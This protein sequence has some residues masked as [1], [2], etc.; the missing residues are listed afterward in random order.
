M[1]AYNHQDIIAIFARGS[2]KR[3]CPEPVRQLPPGVSPLEILDAIQ[4]SLTRSISTANL[5]RILQL[6]QN[7]DSSQTVTDDFDS[8][9]VLADN[10]K[11]PQVGGKL[12]E[13]SIG[14]QAT[15]V[16]SIPNKPEGNDV[17]S[18]PSNKHPNSA[19]PRLSLPPGDLSQLNDAFLSETLAQQMRCEGDII[20]NDST[21]GST[22]FT[23]E[24]V[25]LDSPETV[26]NIEGSQ[27]LP[28][29]AS[30]SRKDL[31]GIPT[32]NP[33]VIQNSS[34][35][36]EHLYQDRV[37]FK[38]PNSARIVFSTCADQPV[39]SQALS[40]FNG[41]LE[42]STKS[43]MR[44]SQEQVLRDQMEL[45]R[46]NSTKM[47]RDARVERAIASA[48]DAKRVI[49]SRATADCGRRGEHGRNIASGSIPTQAT[50]AEIGN[51]GGRS[52]VIDN[53]PEY[54]SNVSVSQP[55]NAALLERTPQ[56]E[57]GGNPSHH[58]DL[59]IYNSK[60]A[61]NNK[62]ERSGLDRQNDAKRKLRIAAQQV[63]KQ[64]AERERNR[65]SRRQKL[66]ANPPNYCHVQSLGQDPSQNVSYG[67]ECSKSI[68]AIELSEKDVEKNATTDVL[69]VPVTVG[70][71]PYTSLHITAASA[72]AI[73]SNT[74][75]PN[76]RSHA[77]SSSN[78]GSSNATVTKSKEQTKAIETQILER[79]CKSQF[80]KHVNSGVLNET[81]SALVPDY[82][83]ASSN[84]PQTQHI[85]NNI[86]SMLDSEAAEKNLG[87][88][89]NVELTTSQTEG[90]NGGNETDLISNPPP[91]IATGH[92][93]ID[94]V[95]SSRDGEY[96]VDSTTLPIIIGNHCNDH[97]GSE[98]RGDSNSIVRDSLSDTTIHGDVA[99]HRQLIQSNEVTDVGKTTG[100]E[101]QQRCKIIG[102]WAIVEADNSKN[103]ASQASM[104]DSENL[105][106]ERMRDL[107]CKKLR[108]QNISS[109]NTIQ[110]YASNK[111]QKL[112]IHAL[113]SSGSKT[114]TVH[115]DNSK[116]MHQSIE[117]E[118]MEPCISNKGPRQK[119]MQ[120]TVQQGQ[121]RSNQSKS[122]PIA[123]QSMSSRL[124]KR[125]GKPQAHGFAS[126]NGTPITKS[127]K[128]KGQGISSGA[129][130]S[131]RSVPLSRRNMH[132]SDDARILAIKN[133][134]SAY[135]AQK[136]RDIDVLEE[137]H[138]NVEVLS[139]GHVGPPLSH[140][141]ESSS[142]SDEDEDEEQ[143]KQR[144]LL[145]HSS[146]AT[147]QKVP[148][149]PVPKAPDSQRPTYARKGIGGKTILPQA[150]ANDDSKPEDTIPKA[151]PAAREVSTPSDSDT[152]KHEML[153][154]YTV[155]RT[156]RTTRTTRPSSDSDSDT[157][158]DEPLGTFLT[159]AE[160]N[161][162]ATTRLQRLLA[163]GFLE[164]AITIATDASG[165]QT[166]HYLTPSTSTH[167]R[168]TRAVARKVRL[169]PSAAR[170]PRL[171]YG[172]YHR[173]IQRFRTST[174]PDTYTY[175]HL[176]T[177]SL[178]DLANR[179]AGRAWLA[180]QLRELAPTAY[181]QQVTAV[182]LQ[183]EMREALNRL[184][185]EG[186]AFRRNAR[187]WKGGG[188]AK[189]EEE[190]EV[191][192]DE[193]EVWGPRN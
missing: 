37:L 173:V 119:K 155:T 132:L 139:N 88:L 78:I 114:G 156:T 175:L 25:M 112:E 171:V 167:I 62:T 19:E 47:Q 33:K 128:I 58:N 16:V 85:N 192:V 63:R 147:T 86:N 153:W 87:F 54:P 79:D 190:V 30:T 59:Q 53:V 95:A 162:V 160:A 186:V 123:L 121:Q 12:P 24:Y 113:G 180:Y 34:Q 61:E 2:R 14:H 57:S 49:E 103:D 158:L 131:H 51:S 108:T 148:S 66:T 154:H 183:N 81:E 71:R 52:I 11:E 70:H 42:A 31:C 140:I 96:T 35:H 144:R 117:Q 159:R 82:A 187:V 141:C 185:G 27:T 6:P 169:P 5:E 157:A 188:V 36:K 18:I 69:E 126:L 172:V 164:T 137:D 56:D 138:S 124:N 193:R 107:E 116:P 134:L 136:L 120:D 65:N 170:L 142:S 129:A 100:R 68:H 92:K 90:K 21:K 146:S 168:V 80:P 1:A 150:S 39:G 189:V 64:M 163:S 98:H 143:A 105:L 75:T 44:S 9:L 135:D 72:S 182:E 145:K 17:E 115:R 32:S 23:Q 40:K 111:R 93:D 67:Q 50:C 41:T 97:N 109:G 118:A 94:V 152:T 106:I 161:K 102:Q 176:G 15:A 89:L 178:L 76:I 60:I 101:S 20:V 7:R 43:S 191:W 179:A 73:H 166:C 84:Q 122:E 22:S 127:R 28:K 104:T 48:A 83:A 10:A 38:P 110:Q 181:A 13:A 149:N 174:T 99:E 74:K 4:P 184:E 55:I 77:E 130:R 91:E 8:H 151:E 177:F 165:L 45:R 26:S 46:Q 3:V 125:K 29:L 133:H